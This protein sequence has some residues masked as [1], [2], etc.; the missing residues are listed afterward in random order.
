MARRRTAMRRIREVLR[1]VHEGGYSPTEVSA[2][3]GLARTTVRRFLEKAADAELS[4]P[5]P[6]DVDD[7]QLEERLFGWRSAA[8]SV[9][10]RP[11]PDREE[12]HRELRR[13]GVT[14]HLVW[15]EYKQRF[16][17]GYEYTWFTIQYR[18]L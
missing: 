8:A 7:Y 3:T 11:E 16:P 9:G 18:Q 17:S 12:V 5:L 13:P 15:S 2:A 4:W 10:G 14:L 1:L 6:D